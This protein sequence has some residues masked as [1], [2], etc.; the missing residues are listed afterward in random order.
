MEKNVFVD[1]HAHLHH[2][3]LKPYSGDLSLAIQSARDHKVTHILCVCISP[4]ELTVLREIAETYP[5][6]TIS[7][8]VHPNETL[9][10]EDEPSEADLIQWASHPKVVALGET[11]LDYYRTEAGLDGQRE[12]FRRHIR[13]GNYL[14]KPLIVHTRNAQEDTLRLLKEERADRARGVLHCFTETWEMAQ[15]AMDMGFYISFAG[16]V[17]FKN[18]I[19]IQEVVKKMPLDRILIETD[20]PYL[21]PVPYR[22]KPN[23]PAYV[24]FVA[25]MIAELKQLSIEEVGRQTSQNFFDLFLGGR[26]P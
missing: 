26:L 17:T 12:R 15:K 24:R 7:A 14:Q 1:S 21:A 22:G 13:A 23:E 6:I 18:A 10:L 16:I 8:G 11:G 4:S 20:S 3:D 25:A 9:S 2:L 19:E 5:D